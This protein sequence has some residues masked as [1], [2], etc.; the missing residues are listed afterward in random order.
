M[1]KFKKNPEISGVTTS[2]TFDSSKVG[3]LNISW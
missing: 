1:K 3:I 2:A